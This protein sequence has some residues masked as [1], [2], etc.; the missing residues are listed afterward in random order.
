PD[1]PSH[2]EHPMFG[3]LRHWPAALRALRSSQ[4][5]PPQ[6]RRHLARRCP[7]LEQLEGRMVLSAFHVTTLADGGPGS[8]REA[9]ARSNVHPG[10]DVIVFQEG[11]T[12]T[13]A[14]TGGELDLTDDLT[15]NGPGAD[16]L[17]VS[18]SNL[19]R[20]FQVEPGETVSLS[21]LTIAG[22]NAGS[23]NGGGIDNFGALTVSDSVFSGNVATIG[24]G[25]SNEGGATR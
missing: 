21:G 1:L 3:P 18:G 9:V 20:V 17:T 8:L 5:G 22:G 13:I 11:L 25:R 16:R 15:I 12:G 6:P 14:L 2:E 24:G 10:A 19:S 7:P 23:G 4:A